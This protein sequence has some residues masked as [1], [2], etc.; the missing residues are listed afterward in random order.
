[1]ER[2]SAMS[3]DEQAKKH[4]ETGT[5]LLLQGFYQSACEEFQKALAIDP[6][7]VNAHFNWGNTLYAQGKYAVAI[8]RYEQCIKIDTDFAYACHNIANCHWTQGDY[9]EGRKDWEKA[10][11]VYERTKEKEKAEGNAIFFNTTAS[12]STRFLGT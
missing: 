1:M 3:Y 9:K 4:F 8:Q 6:T 2:E 5:T 12:C 7:Y 11:Q 10:C